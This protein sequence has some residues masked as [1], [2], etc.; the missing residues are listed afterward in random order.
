MN[1]EF[2]RRQVLPRV[3]AQNIS[4]LT[5]EVERKAESRAVVGKKV[6]ATAASKSAEMVLSSQSPSLSSLN[7]LCA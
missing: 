4:A 2:N 3:E 1:P 5:I 6:L 7:S